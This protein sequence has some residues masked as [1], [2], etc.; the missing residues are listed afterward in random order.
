MHRKRRRHPFADPRRFKVRIT[1]CG[2]TIMPLSLLNHLRCRDRLPASGR[3]TPLPIPHD[4]EQ[5]R[6]YS[7]LFPNSQI[8]F[9]TNPRQTQNH[10][11]GVH[12]ISA[13]RMIIAIVMNEREGISHLGLVLRMP[14]VVFFEYRCAETAVNH[15]G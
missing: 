11:F 2:G 9:T 7:T 10:S 4:W 1:A 15:H 8:S 12:M 13:V 5:C 14:K 3:L 6:Y